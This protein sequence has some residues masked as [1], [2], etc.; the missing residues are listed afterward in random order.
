[1]EQE[2]KKVELRSDYSPNS[3]AP[4]RNKRGKSKGDV[5]KEATT[6][7]AIQKS[8]GGRGHCEKE[9]PNR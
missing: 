9:G 2:E 5:R 7:G 8:Y 3:K 4:L 6:G 1:M